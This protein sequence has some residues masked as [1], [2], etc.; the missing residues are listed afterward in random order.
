MMT[1]LEKEKIRLWRMDGW[2]YGAIAKQMGISENTVKT[3]CRRNQLTSVEI[4]AMAG[5]CRE[6]GEALPGRSNQKFCND[7]CRRAWWREHPELVERK[8]FYPVVCA[9]CGKE[10]KSYGQSKRKYCC[11][12]CYIAARFGKGT[13]TVEE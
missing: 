2:G 6:C 9:Y 4:N 12:A 5:F 13:Q 10:F 11:H 8:A 1:N 3:F 7:D